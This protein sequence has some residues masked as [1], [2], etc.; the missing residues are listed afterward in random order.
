MQDDHVKLNGQFEMRE[1]MT[2]LN[3]R[4]VFCFCAF[5]TVMHFFTS[6]WQ[7]AIFL[8]INTLQPVN[9]DDMKHLV[10]VL[11]Y[12]DLTL[13]TKNM[14]KYFSTIL[15]CLIYVLLTLMQ[16]AKKGYSALF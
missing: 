10:K 6:R 2:L 13:K 7:H 15:V 3:C 9:A 14:Y 8:Y 4:I 5:S 16:S 12:S 11:K 1:Q